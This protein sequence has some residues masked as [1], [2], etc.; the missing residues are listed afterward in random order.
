MAEQVPVFITVRDRVEPLR[1]LLA[2]LERAGLHEVW[3]ID[4]A[5]TYAPTVEFL[6]ATTHH[7][8]HT[9][10]NLGH[11]APWLSGTVQRHAHGRFYVVTDPDVVPDED[12]P[13]DAIDHFRA[14]LDRYPDI[15]KVGFGIRTDDLPAHYLLRDDV[16]DWERPFWTDEVEPGVFRA[17]IDTTF[18]LYRPL[19]RRDDMLRS[20]RT[21]APYV[22]RHLPWYVDSAALSEEDRYYREHADSTVSNWDRD[23]LAWW[24]QRRLGPRHDG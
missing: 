17:G 5:S 19:D 7:V 8:V 18:A 23:Q 1:E 3:L 13:L 24:K 21:G 22:A 14:L 6:A 4:N 9:R 11:R 2:W 10:R 15:D 20:L 12:S 16:I